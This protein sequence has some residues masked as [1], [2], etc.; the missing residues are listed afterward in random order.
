MQIIISKSTVVAAVR[1]SEQIDLVHNTLFAV[2]ECMTK[3][4]MPQLEEKI[5]NR[6]VE[7][8]SK[9]IAE[10]TF[11]KAITIMPSTDNIMVDINDEFII[12]T[13]DIAGEAIV[14]AMKLI[15]TIQKQATS[16]V[17]SYSEKWITVPSKK[18]V[19]E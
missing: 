13:V 5:W 12:D 19:E 16:L 7:K 15:A 14:T 17:V 9:S 4:G 10:S 1:K 3:I 2:G 18:V 11:D 8:I 6:F